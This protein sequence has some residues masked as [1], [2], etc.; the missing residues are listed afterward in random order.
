MVFKLQN[1]K[2]RR[3]NVSTLDQKERYQFGATSLLAHYFATSMKTSENLT[4]QVVSH[5]ICYCQVR[6]NK[7]SNLGTSRI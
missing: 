4:R 2:R 1:C 5:E 7:S 3:E 6:F